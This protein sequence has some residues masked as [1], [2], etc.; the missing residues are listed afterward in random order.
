[1]SKKK[2]LYVLLHVG[3]RSCAL[4]LDTDGRYF[5]DAGVWEVGSRWD[6]DRLL[7]VGKDEMAW[8]TGTELVECTREVWATDNAGYVRKSLRSPQ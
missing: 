4:R 7:V 6:G 5:R 3:A 8:A 2:P 1:M